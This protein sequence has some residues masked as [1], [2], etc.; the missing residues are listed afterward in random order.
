ME[1]KGNNFVEMDIE[2]W[3][4]FY[5]EL[6]QDFHQTIAKGLIYDQK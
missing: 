4:Q 1:E 2:D 5:E 6:I 3:N